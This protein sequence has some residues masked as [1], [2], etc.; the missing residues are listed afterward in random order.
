VS[1]ILQSNGGQEFEVTKVEEK[2]AL[3]TNKLHPN[4][5]ELNALNY[6]NAPNDHNHLNVCVILCV[7]AC[8]SEA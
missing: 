4:I 8:W 6:L 3:N 5:N 7:S 2:E 1:L